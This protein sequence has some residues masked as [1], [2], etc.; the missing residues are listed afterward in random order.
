MGGLRDIVVALRLSIPVI[1]HSE[2]MVEEYIGSGVYLP[3]GCVFVGSVKDSP[4]VSDSCIRD[5]DTTG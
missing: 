1:I 2:K 3:S 4:K 5:A